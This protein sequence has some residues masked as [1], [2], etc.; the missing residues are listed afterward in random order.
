MEPDDRYYW[1]GPLPETPDSGQAPAPWTDTK[2]VGKP[3]V[4]VDAYDR[5]SGSAVYPSDVALP[6][7]LHAAILWCPHAH[8]MVKSVDSAAAE[9]MPGV[10]AVLKD[11]VTGTNI[12]WFASQ[13]GFT[14]RLFDP[15]CRM[16]GEEVAAVAAD[17]IYQAWDAVRAIRVD[18]DVLPHVVTFVRAATGCPRPT[19]TSAATWTRR[20]RRP[21]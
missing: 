12:P 10:R 16:E 11:G 19:R 7:M 13:G 6:D 20:S 17:T 4:R 1:D 14:S 18:Y 15:H 8:A 3:I 2:I 5:V 21:R 9:K